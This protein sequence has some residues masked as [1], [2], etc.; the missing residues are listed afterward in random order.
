MAKIS[1]RGEQIRQFILD[2]IEQHP[3]DITNFSAKTF[4]IS[5]QAVNKHIQRL[6]NRK[7]FVVRGATRGRSY[8]LRNLGQWEHIYPL[9]PSLEEHLVWR[10]D[11]APKLGQLAEN[12][13]DIWRYGF[14][15]MLNN[16]IQHSSARNINIRL[17]KTAIAAE[18]TIH[19]DGEGIFKKI[20]RDM[21]LSDERHAVFE[22]SKGKLTSD[23]DNHRG[24]GIFF[25]S[26][27]FDDFGVLS[28]NVYFSHAKNEVENWVL[29]N[30]P[31][32]SG[33]IVFMKL[34]DNTATTIKQVFEPF[35]T[36]G[37]DG[38]T[39]TVGSVRL[40]QIGD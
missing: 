5:R 3:K 22:L 16:A 38:F 20:Q 6:M 30:R 36:G 39:K 24:E 2:N 1:L 8:A 12:V 19:D 32:K 11:I 37:K 10:N 29:E 23:P 4:G 13:L 40:A 28:G 27:I 26:R 21:E 9:E 34:K 14:T 31:P 17:K 7:V 33:T 35:T 18:I 25:T 15:E